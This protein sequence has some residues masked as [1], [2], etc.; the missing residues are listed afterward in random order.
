MSYGFSYSNVPAH[1]QRYSRWDGT[2][3]IADFNADDVMN[4]IS[5]D[6]LADGDLERA[7]QRL[8]RW[9]MDR[10]DDQHMPGIRDLMDRL[11]AMRQRELNRYDIGSVLE[12][13]KER[14]EEIKRLEREGIQERLE[15]ANTPQQSQQGESGQGEQQG[16]QQGQQGQ[17]GMQGQRGQPGQSSSGAMQ[18]PDAAM[19]AFE[20]QQAL[21]E[22]LQ[23]MAERKLEQLHNL[24][25]DPAGQIRALQDYEFMDP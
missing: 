23:K 1:S 2:Q 10:P 22:M 16:S 19:D 12:D 8:M 6:L 14:L 11:K 7:L 3:H 17:Q 21:R 25:E 4:A 20:E 24:P 15:A 13:I 5:D 9:G 18:D